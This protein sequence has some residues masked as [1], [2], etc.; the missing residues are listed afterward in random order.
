MDKRTFLKTSSTAL[1]GLMLSRLTACQQAEPRTNWAGNLQYSTDNLFLPKSVEEVQEV[2]K[3]CTKL[4]GLGSKHSFNSI[5]DSTDNQLSLQ[6]LNKVVALDKAAGTVTVEGGMRY[7]EV[8]EYLHQNGFALHNLASLPHISIAG[9]CA[10]ATHGSGIKNGNLATAV[11][12]IELVNAAGEVISLTQANDNEQ[13]LGAVVGLGGL[14]IVTKV[15]LALQPTFQMKQVVYKNLPM[16]ELEANFNTIMSSGYSVSLFTDWSNQNINQVWIKSKV[17]ATDTP[18]A[19]DFY[20]ATLSAKNL[21]PLEDHSA[22]NCTEQLGVPGPWYERLPHFR[23]GFTPSSGKE[24]Q[25]EYFVPLEHAYK[26]IM[27]IEKLHEKVT[28]H[29]FISEIRAIDADELWMSPHYKQPSV[30]IHFT[31]KPDW[32][33]VKQLLPLIE[34]QL[35]PFNGRPHW[36]KLFT[37]APSVLQSR[38]Q[39]LTDFKALMSHH[40]PEGKFRNAFIDTHLFGS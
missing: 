16:K 2:V 28:P 30:A 34:E 17:E 5:A 37:L 40:D 33:A 24:L 6:A 39:K 9:A 18:P 8:C 14:G 11:R 21:H 36:G 10:T 4:R 15:T 7:G 19:A 13:F 26:A 31:W 25:A 35:A 29:L 38:I 27:A 1:A 12:G 3:K 32:P 23:M 22:E 20:G